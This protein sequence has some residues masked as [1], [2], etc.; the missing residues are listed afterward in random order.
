MKTYIID[1][2]SKSRVIDNKTKNSVLF[3]K[4]NKNHAVQ[5]CTYD[6]VLNLCRD[7]EFHDKI[8]RLPIKCLFDIIFKL[9]ELK[10]TKELIF[11]HIKIKL[12][13]IKSQLDKFTDRVHYYKLELKDINNR[14]WIHPLYG[15]ETISIYPIEGENPTSKEKNSHKTNRPILDIEIINGKLYARCYL[16]L[17][18]PAKDDESY[19]EVRAD[20][21]GKIVLTNVNVINLG[22]PFKALLWCEDYLYNNEHNEKANARPVIRSFLIPLNNAADLIQGT[23]EYDQKIGSRPVDQDRASGQFSNLG[24]KNLYDTKE[25]DKGILKPLEGSLVSFFYNDSDYNKLDDTR[26]K[27]FYLED[28]QEFLTGN[29]GKVG[30]FTKYNKK[31]IAAQ[32]NRAGYKAS[33][34]KEYEDSLFAYYD[35]ISDQGFTGATRTEKITVKNIP[36]IKAYPKVLFDFHRPHIVYSIEMFDYLDNSGNG[37]CLYHALAGRNLSVKEVQ[38]VRRDVANVRRERDFYEHA[39]SR[40][41]AY[42]I[43]IYAATV[44]Q[45]PALEDKRSLLPYINKISHNQLADIQQRMGVYAGHEEIIQW[46]QVF[47]KSVIVIDMDGTILRFTALGSTPLP[48]DLSL[49]DFKSEIVLY[50]SGNHW[51][52]II[53]LKHVDSV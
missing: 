33:F 10:L 19:K 27:K 2:K 44:L 48:K 24:D 39:N 12:L 28:L 30:D 13:N 6:Y 4:I 16:A 38:K 40:Q 15:N 49:I 14:I 20:K 53:G 35:S 47:H 43:H 21:D 52:R 36:K 25:T 42:N 45:T 37:D 17:F 5:L 32:H 23:N 29:R 41:L 11:N 1:S 26:Q 7:K 3:G 51:V 31:T 8:N 50:N 34:S 18:A 46:C 22:N 9:H